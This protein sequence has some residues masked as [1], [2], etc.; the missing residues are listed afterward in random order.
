MWA[1]AAPSRLQESPA[2]RLWTAWRRA[3]RQRP[4]SRTSRASPPLS[5]T[6]DPKSATSRPAPPRALSVSEHARELARFERHS[7]IKVRCW[8]DHTWACSDMASPE[9][10][11]EA[12]ADGVHQVLFQCPVCQALLT[13]KQAF[14]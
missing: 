5:A 4:F 11:G 9:L 13:R 7:P 14:G 8:V 10:I 2:W 12:I 6:R 3:R 1:D